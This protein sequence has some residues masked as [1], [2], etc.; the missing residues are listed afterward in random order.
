MATVQLLTL[1]H[2]LLGY[3]ITEIYNLIAHKFGSN[4]Y[5][6]E[7]KKTMAIRAP[8][9]HVS[10]LSLKV[11]T[12]AISNLKTLLIHS[13]TAR[14]CHRMIKVENMQLLLIWSSR[15]CNVG[16]KPIKSRQVETCL[17]IPL[18]AQKRCFLFKLAEQCHQLRRGLQIGKRSCDDPNRKGIC[19]DL[20]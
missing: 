7:C 16:C 1:L 14:S 11:G 2:H 4:Y 6:F 10:K 8:N 15:I 12:V 13:L 5:W 17:G 9:T 18:S 19:E 20:L 3:F